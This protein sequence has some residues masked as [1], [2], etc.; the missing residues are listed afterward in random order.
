MKKTF[1]LLACVASLFTACSGE[2]K[3]EVPAE[4]IA[5]GREA[6]EAGIDAL[7][8]DTTLTKEAF[9]EAYNQLVDEVFARHMNDSLGLELFIEQGVETWDAKTIKANFDAADTLI[10]NN[11]RAQRYV[12]LAKNREKTGAGA[13]YVNI[14]GQNIRNLDETMSI[15]TVLAEGK[16]ILL[17]FFASWCP[18]CRKCIKTELPEV[19]K[20]YEGKM[21]ILGIDCWENKL[22]DIQKAMGE[23]PITWRVIYTG[24]REN[25][26]VY[27]YGVSS[28]PTLVVLDKNGKIRGR[29]HDLEELQ[30]V[31]DV[32]VAE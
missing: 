9:R 16:P 13:D 19:A 22:E 15:Q 27:G 17:D 5:E 4:T 20:K 14:E 1:F 30:E 12:M 6:L 11:E 18:P 28:I 7:R 21:T 23:L 8:E 25:S 31:I 26:P 3:A 10:Q 29:S 24:G 32:V 2:Q